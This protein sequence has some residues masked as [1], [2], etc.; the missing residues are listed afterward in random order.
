MPDLLR[1]GVGAG[2]LL[3]GIGVLYNYVV[4]V[5][6]ER[7]VQQ[8]IAQGERIVLTSPKT[9]NRL[10]LTGDGFRFLD[11]HGHPLARLTQSDG[12]PKLTLTQWTVSIYDQLGQIGKKHSQTLKP[13]EGA[14]LDLYATR[15]YITRCEFCNDNASLG[16][17]NGLVLNSRDWSGGF[18]DLGLSESNRCFDA[19][20]TCYVTSIFLDEPL[21][22]SMKSCKTKR[23]IP[24]DK[25]KKSEGCE[26]V[27]IGSTPLD[28]G[29]SIALR[30]DGEP[31]LMIG[32]A[33]L[34]APS[35]GGR[36]ITPIS[37]ITGFDKK[38]VVVWKIPGR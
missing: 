36:E 18:S 20:S 13:K 12:N 34:T 22:L 29:A 27:N 2:A 17:E 23:G 14:S 16:F 30:E 19:K 9:G 11:K 38:G 15:V 5:P 26:S 35:V 3:A 33:S 32:R 21:G 28:D 31:R 25:T 37:Q 6:H 10:V 4:V 7:A 1:A 24:L 8:R